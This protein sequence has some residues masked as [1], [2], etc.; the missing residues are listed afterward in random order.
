MQV[1]TILNR[2][3]KHRSFVYGETRLL[4]EGGEPVLEVDVHPRRNGRPI[5]SGCGL[6]RPGYDRL[7]PR[8]FQFVPLWGILVFFVYVMRRVNCPTCGVVVEAVPWAAGKSQLTTTYAWF[9]AGWAKRLSWLEV[10]R[11][12]RTSWDSVYRAVQMAVAWGRAHV[13]LSGITAIGIDEMAWAKGHRYIT[14]VYQLDEGRR[15]L[16]WVGGKRR[17]KTLLGFFRWF[18]EARTARLRF[19]C[20]DM[21]RPY[22]KVIAKKAGHALHILDRFHIAMHL[23]K[24]I[25]K[26]RAEEAR[27][28]AA[29]GYEP[30]LKRTRWL[31]LKRPE[32]LTEKQDAKLAD[33]LRYNLRTVRAYLLKEDLQGL[34]EYVS[35]HW[36]GK[37]MD[38]WCTRAMR[39]KLEP[40]KQVA[41]MLRAH[42]PLILNW[43][44]AKGAI[45][46]GAVEGLNG[47]AK[48][49]TRKAYGFRTQKTLEI[50]LYHQLGDL[51]EPQQTHRFC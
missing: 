12:F 31:L 33:L 37:F 10:S 32:N 22:L 26:V 35:P 14:V 9:L 11:T 43:F 16:L 4:D 5:C 46:A 38:R 27:Q 51:P 21:W 40:M 49:A 7:T 20:S 3:Q 50:A 41:R 2:V 18:G 19:I 8:R 23:S 47:K 13:D 29:R 15:R 45:S 25:D 34:W 36:A 28:L 1:K 17:V 24:A 6:P 42:R 30:V 44:R 48:V 39:S